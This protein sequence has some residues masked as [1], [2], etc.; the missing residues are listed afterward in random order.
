MTEKIKKIS[1]MVRITAENQQVFLT[2][3]AEH[4]DQLE[5]AIAE[6]TTR[7]SELEKNDV[8]TTQAQ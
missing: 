7:I 1:D 3:I 8:G 5:T 6:L 4:I 2:Q